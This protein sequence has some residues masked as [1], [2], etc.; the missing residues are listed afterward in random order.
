[1]QK[2][3]CVGPHFEFRRRAFRSSP[4]GSAADGQNAL[5]DRES[6]KRRRTEDEEK[7]IDHERDEK[8]QRGLELC[9]AVVC[10]G[11][12]FWPRLIVPVQRAMGAAQEAAFPEEVTHSLLAALRL[13]FENSAPARPQLC[14][15][16]D[17]RAI[18]Y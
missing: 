6:T 2:S 9:R 11:D 10:L 14:D 15:P 4:T 18:C 5:S 3:Y 7:M 1:M 17:A 8:A 16:C 12:S 13:C